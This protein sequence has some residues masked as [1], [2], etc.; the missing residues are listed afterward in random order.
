MRIYHQQA[1]INMKQVQ[2][3]YKQKFDHHRADIHYNVGDQVLKRLLINPSKLSA[4]YS[5][6]MTIIKK[7][8]PTYWEQDQDDQQVYQVHVSQLRSFNFNHS[9]K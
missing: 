6:P 1:Q 8:H 2:Q 4:I 5:N 7:Q 9:L 3:K